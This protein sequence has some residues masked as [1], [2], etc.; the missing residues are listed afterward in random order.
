MR[1]LRY[2][3][4]NCEKPLFCVS[5]ARDEGLVVDHHP[6]IVVPSQASDQNHLL[7]SQC[8]CYKVCMYAR[9]E[10]IYVPLLYLLK[11]SVHA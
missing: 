8:L 5:L 7:L 4:Q 11:M 3:L 2:L 6:L 9:L 1:H 10:V